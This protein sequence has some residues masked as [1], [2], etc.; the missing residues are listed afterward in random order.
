MIYFHLMEPKRLCRLYSLVVSQLRQR[1]ISKRLLNY[2]RPRAFQQLLLIVHMEEHRSIRG[3]LL[4]GASRVASE[5]S[6]W[7]AI[8]QAAGI[9][10]VAFPSNSGMGRTQHKNL[11]LLFG[12]QSPRRMGIYT[13]MSTLAGRKSW[14]STRTKAIRHQSLQTKSFGAQILASSKAR[15]IVVVSLD[16]QWIPHK[17]R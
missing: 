16:F 5:A 15:A 9:Q 3:P 17:T 1:A 2:R 14:K 6:I 11:V 12:F 4:W 10:S 8:G 13:R 7:S